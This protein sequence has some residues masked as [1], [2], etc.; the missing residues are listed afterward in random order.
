MCAG[1]ARPHSC[2][3]PHRLPGI[4]GRPP[5]MDSGPAVACHSQ[6]EGGRGVDIPLGDGIAGKFAVLGI[7][8][9]MQRTVG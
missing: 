5:V 6:V 7:T 2:Q 1:R 4:A 3:P 8:D 9:S